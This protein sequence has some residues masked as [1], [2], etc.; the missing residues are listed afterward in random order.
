MNESN[1]IPVFNPDETGSIAFEILA[2]QFGFLTLGV[3]DKRPSIVSSEEEMVEVLTQSIE[4]LMPRIKEITGTDKKCRILIYAVEEE[5]QTIDSKNTDPMAL[6]SIVAE[7]LAGKSGNNIP[8]VPENFSTTSFIP[9]PS[10]P[11]KPND[12]SDGSGMTSED[13]DTVLDHA[14]AG[15]SVLIKENGHS[16]GKNK[17]Y[18]PSNK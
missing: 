18:Y 16:K 13:I 6:L 11:S 4:R 5:V 14:K 7:M 8:P 17:K 12:P 9:S 10:S 15:G 3:G 1:N 2:A